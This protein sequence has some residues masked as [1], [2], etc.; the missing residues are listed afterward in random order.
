MKKILPT[1]N[2]CP[3]GRDICRWVISGLANVQFFIHNIR[4]FLTLKGATTEVQDHIFR[5]MSNTTANMLKEDLQFIAPLSLSEVHEVQSFILRTLF[6]LEK[7]GKLKINSL[8]PSQ[9]I[10]KKASG[11][12]VWRLSFYK[13]FIYSTSPM[14]TALLG[15]TVSAV[16]ITVTGKYSPQRLLAFITSAFTFWSL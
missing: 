1:S 9:I 13:T 14:T 2:P 7:K 3:A 6:N 11:F 4:Q 12:I 10:K 15:S 8:Q 5:N 16:T